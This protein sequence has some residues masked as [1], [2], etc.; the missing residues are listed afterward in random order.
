VKRQEFAQ[1]LSEA[2]EVFA[3]AHVVKI[4]VEPY[5]QGFVI[6]AL[7]EDRVLWRIEVD[8]AI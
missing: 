2:L 3:Q 7:D 4:K 8:P 1:R 5:L 6:Y